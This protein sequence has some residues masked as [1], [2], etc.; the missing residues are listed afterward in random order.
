[1]QRNRAK[2]KIYKRVYTYICGSVFLFTLSGIAG[3]SASIL[4]YT[5]T[6]LFLTDDRS[7]QMD[8]VLSPPKETSSFFSLNSGRAPFAPLESHTSRCVR[9]HAYVR[10]LHSCTGIQVQEMERTIQRVV[11]P[12]DGVFTSDAKEAVAPTRHVRSLMQHTKCLLMQ[13]PLRGKS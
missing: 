9:A 1:M 2:W 6:P 12:T 11:R 13:T 5:C 10:R 4:P 3:T 7:R 8:T